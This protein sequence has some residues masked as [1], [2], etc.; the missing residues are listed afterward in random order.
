MENNDWR[1]EGSIWDFLGSVSWCMVVR[2][3]SR[4][5]ELSSSILTNPK[6]TEDKA[7]EYGISNVALAKEMVRIGRTVLLLMGEDLPGGSNDY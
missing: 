6:N 7:E 3:A 2:E 4:K 1:W 5:G